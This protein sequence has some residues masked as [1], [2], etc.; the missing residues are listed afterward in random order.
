MRCISPMSLF[1]SKLGKYIEVP[2]GK[3]NA[4]LSNKRAEWTFRLKEELKVSKT[5]YFVTLTYDI[6]KVPLIFKNEKGK[7]EKRKIPLELS[8]RDVQL[9][10]K[11]LRKVQKKVTNDSIR[12]YLVGEYGSQ[13]MRAH[14]HAI[15]F[16][17]DM[18]L[19][20]K[21]VDIW[22]YGFV[23]I[24]SVTGASIHY[25]T[26]YMINKFD[27]EDEVIVQPFALMSRRPALGSNYLKTKKYHKQG[28]FYT[29]VSQGRKQTMPRYYRD[30]IFNK[31]EQF[32]HKKEMEKLAQKIQE[33]RDNELM[34]RGI[35][36]FE[37]E[38]TNK[39]DYIRRSNKIVKKSKL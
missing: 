12:Y 36:P 18:S 16:N 27:R 2:C 26:K 30:K 4:C 37:M 22:N 25:T 11:K 3:C 31:F 6:N 29:V 35:N 1:S 15:L 23:Y 10:M 5:A 39:E 13:T 9:F 28:K 20:N 34:S 19:K 17:L 32:E 7:Y 21:I 14:Y 8:K 38:V 24:G 33:K